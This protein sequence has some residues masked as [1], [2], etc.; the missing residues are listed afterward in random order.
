[1]CV[2]AHQ[3]VARRS[4]VAAFSAART[5]PESVTGV[6]APHRIMSRTRAIGAWSNISPN[7]PRSSSDCAE[8]AQGSDARR[9]VKANYFFLVLLQPLFAELIETGPEPQQQIERQWIAKTCRKAGAND[10]H[11]CCGGHRFCP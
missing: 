11:S 3:D 5:P 2:P 10:I 7:R 6:S 1:M 9:I 8:D 4:L